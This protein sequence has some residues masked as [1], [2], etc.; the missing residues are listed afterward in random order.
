MM[1][2]KIKMFLFLFLLGVV[3]SCKEKIRTKKDIDEFVILDIVGNSEMDT[4]KV[5]SNKGNTEISLI[6]KGKEQKI[7][8]LYPLF[9]EKFKTT[10]PPIEMVY[11]EAN[12]IQT[13]KKSF[14]VKIR[15]TDFKPDSYYIDISLNNSKMFVTNLGIVNSTDSVYIKNKKVKYNLK[16]FLD[17]N[18]GVNI[19]EF[20]KTNF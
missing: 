20:I 14:R 18:K 12:N 3:I 19:L 5:K 17:K 10:I 11:I 2:V 4:L 7:I 15:N 16:N 6:I 9:H 13:N 8:N 1:S